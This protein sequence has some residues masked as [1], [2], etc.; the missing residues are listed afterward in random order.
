VGCLPTDAQRWTFRYG[1]DDYSQRL[2]GFGNVFNTLVN[3]RKPQ[4][5]A[6]YS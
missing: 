5:N 3:F 1:F 4:I 2:D 6:I